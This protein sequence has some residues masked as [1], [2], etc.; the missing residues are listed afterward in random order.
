MSSGESSIQLSPW[1][2]DLFPIFGRFLALA[3]VSTT[4][5]ASP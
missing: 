3:L 2:V 4:S 5:R 1:V